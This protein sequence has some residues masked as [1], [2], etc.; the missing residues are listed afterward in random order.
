MKIIFATGNPA[1]VREI[2]AILDDPATEVMTMKEAGVFCDP[3]ENG[4][5]FRENALIKCR[6]VAAQ[7]PDRDADT[8]IMSD[9]SGLV[10]DAIGGEPGVQSARYMGR[11]TS[12]EIKNRNII[13]RLAGRTG[14]ERSARFECAVGAVLS[15]GT[16]LCAFGTMEGRIAFEPAGS[17]GFGYDPILFLPEYGCTSAEISGEEKNR[18]SHRGK[19]L[20]SMIQI[21]RERGVF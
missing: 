17:G 10:V 11:D 1:K 5:T 15:D 16:E 21:L 2:R 18:I 20:R 6:A 14:E 7:M 12:Y 19:A 9:D 13:D 4:T 8:V 3:E